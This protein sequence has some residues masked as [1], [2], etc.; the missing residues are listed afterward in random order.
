MESEN[1]PF[2]KL[3][4]DEKFPRLLVT[5]KPE[6]KLDNQMLYGAFLPTGMLRRMIDLL[7]RT[8][9]L[10]PCELDING[11]FDAPCPEYFLHRCLAPCVESICDRETYLE[12]IEIVHLILSRQSE[13]ALKKIDWKIERLADAL[14]F[15]LAADWRDCRRTIEEISRNAKWQIAAS[16]M[17][18]VI[19]FSAETDDFTQ[20]HLTTLRRGKAVGRL[21]F[22]AEKK[23]REELLSDFIRGF[24]QFYAP[25]QIYAPQDFPD[26]KILEEK[27]AL[28]FGRKIKI[29]A[30][31]PEKLPPT[32]L[33][34]RKFAASA[35]KYGNQK[36]KTSAEKLSDELKEIFDLTD[37]PRRVECFDVA[38]LAG[39]EI[40]AA[41]VRAVDGVLQKDE[42][43]VWEFEN[44]SEAGALAAA[45]ETRLQL[46]LK[47][48]LAPDVLLIDGGKAQIRAVQKVLKKFNLGNLK[49]VGAVKPPKRH[50]QISHFL[51]VEN[52]RVEFDRHSKAMN[53]LQTL[54][55]AAHTLA[56][57]THRQLHSLV[58]IFQNNETA[59]Q[60]KYLLVPTRYS[61]RGGGAEDLSPIRSL[62]Q[63]GRVIL[64][65]KNN[66]AK[67][68]QSAKN[69]QI[70]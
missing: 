21:N 37:F 47:E 15:E 28:D 49:I 62:T 48:E 55:D 12:T 63:A 53:F 17:N 5:R 27:L 67:I 1:Y 54:R 69:L 8:F 19:T 61:E 41:R 23:R 14:E 26:R 52:N 46:L 35:F 32:V 43:L 45:V 2:L 36:T 24:Y 34:A 70:D 33:T 56:N 38:H 66:N 31:L 57:E 30:Q 59:P 22:P 4:T 10:R 13:A 51:V 58:Q 11:D 9:R 20:I 65:T 64:K 68:N 7:T 42:G 60:V 44:L 39:R 18:D 25:K 29:I 6:N 50:N 3:T 40:V 16:A